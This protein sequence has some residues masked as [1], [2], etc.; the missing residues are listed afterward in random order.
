M[1]QGQPRSV[2]LDFELIRTRLAGSNAADMASVS[3]SYG[4]LWFIDAASMLA[5]DVVLDP[6]GRASI[7][8]PGQARTP[9]RRSSSCRHAR[10]QQVPLKP[11]RQIPNTPQP[12]ALHRRTAG[13][14]ASARGGHLGRC[15]IDTIGGVR[16]LASAVRR[17]QSHVSASY[18][19]HSHPHRPGGM[20]HW[21]L[22]H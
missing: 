18:P 12:S 3:T 22:P 14:T 16:C 11:M 9:P 17:Y 7:P 15:R 13:P 1:E 8:G 20:R 2:R 4:S 6:A 21:H 19:L 5:G 10:R